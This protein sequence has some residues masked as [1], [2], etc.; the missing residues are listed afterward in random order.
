MLREKYSDSRSMLAYVVTLG[1]R[2]DTEESLRAK[3]EALGEIARATVPGKRIAATL[4]QYLALKEEEWLR[5]LR[6]ISLMVTPS[7]YGLLGN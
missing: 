4:N 5:I 1:M 7:L 2:G 3:Y 6:P